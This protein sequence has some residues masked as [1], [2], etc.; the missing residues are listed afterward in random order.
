MVSL[1]IKALVGSSTSG[2]FLFL[3]VKGE[4]KERFASTTSSYS[5]DT[6]PRP[7]CTLKQERGTVMGGLRHHGQLLDMEKGQWNKDTISEF[8]MQMTLFL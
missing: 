2:S 6:E 7:I 3:E 1:A 8:E 4:A 5:G